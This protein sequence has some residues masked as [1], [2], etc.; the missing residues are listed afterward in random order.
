MNLLL[1]INVK[2]V[3]MKSLYRL[4]QGCMVRGGKICSEELLK[5]NENES[6]M[7]GE[8]NVRYPPVSGVGS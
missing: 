4:C 1:E 5:A 2:S 3:L 7:Y 6:R 8:Q